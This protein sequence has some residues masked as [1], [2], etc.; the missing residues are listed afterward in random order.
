MMRLAE[1]LNLNNK[2]RQKG[3]AMTPYIRHL[4]LFLAILLSTNGLAY[5][6]H[7][8]VDNHYD[9]VEVKH[10]G[11]SLQITDKKSGNVLYS[12]ENSDIECLKID[13]TA[14]GWF[15]HVYDE[16]KINTEELHKKICATSIRT[17]LRCV[18]LIIDENGL[19]TL[20]DNNK[21]VEHSL[22]WEEKHLYNTVSWPDNPKKEKS[23]S[24][25]F[26]VAID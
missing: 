17:T 2:P 1:L 4:F 12:I 25:T 9:R 21:N 20:N 19:A 10:N 3:I 26:S 7:F 15:L 13:T 11:P 18:K 22:E 23:L 16:G 5:E 14:A 8:K 24:T 6:T